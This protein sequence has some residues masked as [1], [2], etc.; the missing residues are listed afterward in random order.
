MFEWLAACRQRVFW[1]EAPETIAGVVGHGVVAVAVGLAFG[2]NARVEPVPGGVSP[3]TGGVSIGVEPLG[4]ALSCGSV[5]FQAVVVWQLPH[6]SSN[7]SWCS[8]LEFAVSC[9][10]AWQR[11]HSFVVPSNVGVVPW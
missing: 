1:R 3:P 4:E 9:S 10:R 7:V 5:G 11:A 2:V 8:T 6:A